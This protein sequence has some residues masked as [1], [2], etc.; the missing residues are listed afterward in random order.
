MSLEK[1]EHLEVGSVEYDLKETYKNS[2]KNKLQLVG[3][4]V[5]LDTNWKNWEGWAETAS[6]DDLLGMLDFVEQCVV[7]SREAKEIYDLNAEMKNSTLLP[8]ET[9]KTLAYMEA[10]AS[11]G[12]KY[13]NEQFRDFVRETYQELPKHEEASNEYDALYNVYGSEGKL[14]GM[15]ISLKSKGQTKEVKGLLN[16]TDFRQLD[17][18]M[19]QQYLSEAKKI[20]FK[21]N[22]KA[23]VNFELDRVSFMK[24]TMLSDKTI[25]ES[26]KIKMKVLTSFVTEAFGS[27][28][29]LNETSL[30]YQRELNNYI[31]GEQVFTL[32][33][34]QKMDIPE[35]LAEIKRLKYLNT[36]K[37]DVEGKMCRK[38]QRG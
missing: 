22:D 37:R 11:K 34:F 38:C 30:E 26:W 10:R 7:D 15:R 19:K 2:L 31:G 29:K 6:P 28:K 35:R 36:K 32:M 25:P 1:M 8:K 3:A 4:E 27:K 13:F 24:R 23:K 14:K 9:L 16:K 21:N 20:L 17:G 33:E 5:G 12:D 18:E